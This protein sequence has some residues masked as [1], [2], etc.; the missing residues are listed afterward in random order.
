MLPSQIAITTE[1]PKEYFAQAIVAFEGLQ[2]CDHYFCFMCIFIRANEAVFAPHFDMFMSITLL[3]KKLFGLQGL[4]MIR[5]AT[6]R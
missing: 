2:G 1:W 6:W 3:Q 5:W 4:Y